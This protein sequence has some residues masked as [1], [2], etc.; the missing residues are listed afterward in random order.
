[1]GDGDSSDEAP[2][3]APVHTAAELGLKR[4]AF[5]TQ[6]VERKYSA[7]DIANLDTI[8]TLCMLGS[9]AEARKQILEMW[10][11]DNKPL[12]LPLWLEN[13]LKKSKEDDD[14]SGFSGM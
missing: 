4:V 5:P 7:V 1:M 8:T 10:N 2:F 14:S 13:D 9:V 6:V 3:I 12:E 11:E